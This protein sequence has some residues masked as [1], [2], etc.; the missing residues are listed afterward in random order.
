MQ[1]RPHNPVGESSSPSPP[2]RPTSQ[3]HRLEFG[4]R[5]P[6]GGIQITRTAYQTFDQAAAS[7]SS[8]KLKAIGL[9]ADLKGKSFLDL[10]CNEGFFCIEAKRRGARRIVGIDQ[11]AEFISRARTRGRGIEFLNQ[12]WAELPDEKFDVIVMLSA[13][14]Y[15]ERPRELLARLHDHLTDD[16]LL[17]LE[18]GI[19]SEPGAWRV[20]TQRKTVVYHP[21][22]DMV[23][24]RYLEPFSFRVVG[25]SVDQPGDPVQ[26]WVIHC[27]RRKPNV[28]LITGLSN[29][30]KSTL[31]RQLGG[32][33]VVTIATDAVLRRLVESM[34]RPDTPILR[35][36]EQF[37]EVGSR[38]FGQMTEAIVDAGLADEFGALLAAHV[39]LDEP[40][41]LVEGYALR[42][43]IQASL[44]RNLEGRAVVWTTER[45]TD[46]G[47]SSRITREQAATIESLRWKLIQA[48]AAHQ[49]SI[50]IPEPVPVGADGYE[51]SL[52]QQ[53]DA[54]RRERDVVQAQLDRLTSRRSVR[55]ATW[56]A[57]LGRPIVRGP[58]RVARRL[59]RT[60]FRRPLS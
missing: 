20:W 35:V 57:E 60:V 24:D 14:H 29:D 36:L 51:A 22:M 50:E 56:V 9:P 37:R 26:R 44:I 6:R 12:S 33:R 7:D 38:S 15:E 54:A 13:L 53:R 17:I 43:E 1:R 19:A 46:V 8:A 49:P 27:W 30:G 4:R 28:V 11:S 5:S 18:V 31:A 3:P 52:L 45:F 59:R 2:S 58:R 21:T 41:V 34:Q 16:G 55:A 32:G 25:R 48:K 23:L 10:G 42:G 39:P 47:P 40:T